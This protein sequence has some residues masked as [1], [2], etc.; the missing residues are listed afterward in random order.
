MPLPATGAPVTQ[1]QFDLV[2]A[3]INAGALDD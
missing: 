1:A 2:T 3:W